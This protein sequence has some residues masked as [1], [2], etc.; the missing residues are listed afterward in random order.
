MPLDPSLV[1]QYTRRLAGWI[2]FSLV[3][4]YNLIFF[5]TSHFK[6][7]IFFPKIYFLFPTWYS[8][9]QPRYYKEDDIAPPP[10]PFFRVIFFHYIT[11]PSSQ[12]DILPKRLLKKYYIF[13]HPCSYLHFSYF[14]TK[15]RPACAAMLCPMDPAVE[16]SMGTPRARIIFNVFSSTVLFGWGCRL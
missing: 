13:I 9:Q 4:P 14:V 10:F 5:P 12:L 16:E 11:L 7:F 2:S 3:V 8:A 15:Y 6:N 1:R